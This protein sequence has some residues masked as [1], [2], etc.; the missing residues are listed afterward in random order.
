MPSKSTITITEND[1]QIM[2]AVK[3]DPEVTGH[4]STW[5]T[6]AITADRIVK[7]LVMMAKAEGLEPR[8]EV[9]KN[10]E[11]GHIRITTREKEPADD[12]KRDGG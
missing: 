2:F 6:P 11:T 7:S 12:I 5:H 10:S 8:S 1:K 9:Y 4:P 3:H